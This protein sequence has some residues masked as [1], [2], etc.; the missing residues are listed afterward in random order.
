MKYITALA[1]IFSLHAHSN[2]PAPTPEQRACKDYFFG[3]ITKPIT[4]VQDA[5][6]HGA[7]FV[8]NEKEAMSYM[9]SFDI[10][11]LGLEYD[12][13]LRDRWLKECVEREPVKSIPYCRS[14]FHILHYFR[15]LIYAMENY[16]WSAK[17]KAEANRI[18]WLYIDHIRK[19]KHSFLDLIVT[20]HMLNDLAQRK[21]TSR[22][23]PKAISE[24]KLKMQIAQNVS[25]RNVKDDD[26]RYSCAE[27]NMIATEEAKLVDEYSKKLNAII[28]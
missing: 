11:K 26:F 24:L 28:K 22:V 6:D 9:A 10:S 3:Y 25:R 16:G 5:K 8:K 13:D 1:F 14:D 17:T 21:L 23:N 4:I 12:K 19:T 2:T 15:G 7:R 20:T 27:K 18:T